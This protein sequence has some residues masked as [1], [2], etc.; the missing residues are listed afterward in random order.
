MNLSKAI[1][2]V[3]KAC[4]VPFTAHDLRRTFVTIAEQL[5]FS[6]YLLKRLVNHKVDSD[7]TAG[8]VVFEP[9]R[10]RAAMQAIAEFILARV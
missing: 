4:Q 3:V 2:L 10:L 1:E 6:T 8:Y 7:V 9:E 5:G